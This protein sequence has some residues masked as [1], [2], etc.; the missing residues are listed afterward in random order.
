MPHRSAHNP[1]PTWARARSWTVPIP[2][3]RS[4]PQDFQT[5]PHHRSGTQEIGDP[6]DGTTSTPG[7]MESGTPGGPTANTLPGRTNTRT[8]VVPRSHRA[9][10]LPKHVSMSRIVNYRHAASSRVRRYC[11]SLPRLL[12][13]LVAILNCS[14][15]NLERSH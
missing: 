9:P 15:G 1:M 7:V 13:N 5:G 4:S 6:V 10:K 8:A 11:V 14:T 12:Y 2:T 3:Q